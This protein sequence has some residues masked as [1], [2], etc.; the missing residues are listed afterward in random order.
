MFVTSRLLIFASAT[1]DSRLS[2][3]DFDCS[4]PQRAQFADKSLDGPAVL[5]DADAGDACGSRFE[6][7]PDAFHGDSPESE[8][9]YSYSP[10]YLPQLIQSQR[11]PYWSLDGVSKT[12]PS[13]R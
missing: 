4:L 5:K 9:R 6:T 11:R 12:G 1:F 10:G 13:S 8:D 7:R 3:Y 2:T